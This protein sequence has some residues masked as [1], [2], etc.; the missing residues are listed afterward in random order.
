MKGEVVNC[1]TKLKPFLTK[2]IFKLTYDKTTSLI[3]SAK[4]RRRWFTNW[5]TSSASNHAKRIP[6]Y[7]APVVCLI[8]RKK[9]ENFTVTPAIADRSEGPFYFFIF[10]HFFIFSLI[11]S[12]FI[13]FFHFFIFSFFFFSFF[14][15]PVPPPGPPPPPP[16]LPKNIVL[17]Y[18]NLD[19]KA[20]IWVREEERKKERR[21]KKNAPTETGPL[22]Q[23]HAQDLFVIRVR[24]TPS[25][26]L[27]GFVWT[28]QKKRV[29][30][31]KDGLMRYQFGT[32]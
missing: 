8:G 14:S 7:N 13:S 6:G 28:T 10:L 9:F 31:T 26:R 30:W 22:P 24:G 2:K 17:Y 29:S 1:W 18:E 27:M 12:F 15:S 25:L 20:R 19:F 32:G 5:A 3:L 16:G 23:S 21:R 11:F 4:N